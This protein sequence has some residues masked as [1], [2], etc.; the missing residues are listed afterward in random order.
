MV[1]RWKHYTTYLIT[2][3]G[4]LVLTGCS[5]APTIEQQPRALSSR[6]LVESGSSPTSSSPPIPS[7]STASISSMAAT[8]ADIDRRTEA[9]KAFNVY[10]IPAS[11]PTTSF[12]G[13]EERRSFP[14]WWLDGDDIAAG[15]PLGVLF[16]GWNKIQWQ[17]S[18]AAPLMITGQRLHGP[19]QALKVDLLSG[20]GNGTTADD[21]YSSGTV[22]PAAGCW[23]LRAD[24]EQQHLEATVY[25]YPFACK[26]LNLRERD[27]PNIPVNC[28]PPE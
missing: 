8:G 1:T 28:T 20:I 25:I 26:P 2:V 14:A 17:L 5:L 24:A 11:C 22:F 21:L 4:L 16:Q 9:Q 10:P 18:D 7:G 13:P 19:V 23:K 3:H 12:V 6:A 15:T 27:E